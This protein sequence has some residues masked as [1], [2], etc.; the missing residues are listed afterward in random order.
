MTPID[1]LR[2]SCPEPEGWRVDPAFWDDCAKVERGGWTVLL[3]VVVPG[4]W[5][6]RAQAG[7]V[8]AR[9]YGKDPARAIGDACNG[10][11]DK[12]RYLIEGAP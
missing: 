4:K 7:S 12:L 6:C 10:V 8:V 3:M 2:I 1:H 9:G 5:A 11:A